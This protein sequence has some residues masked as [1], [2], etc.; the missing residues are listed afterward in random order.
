MSIKSLID[1]QTLG[2]SL[3]AGAE[4]G[5]IESIIATEERS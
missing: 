4:P 1:I 2:A 5:K 3:L